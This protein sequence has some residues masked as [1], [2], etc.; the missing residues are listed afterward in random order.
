MSIKHLIFTVLLAGSLG[1]GCANAS[2]FK[3]ENGRIAASST[4][5]GQALAYSC[6]GAKIQGEPG[7]LWAA[8]KDVAKD[9]NFDMAEITRQI[10]FTRLPH[11]NGLCVVARGGPISGELETVLS[12][13]LWNTG[14]KEAGGV[15]GD[16]VGI[17][18][19]AV[20]K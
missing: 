17:G 2:Y 1:L 10:G 20:N 13:W 12:A 19:D 6:K 5:L 4:A 9:Q 18:A 8:L 11:G 3:G 16:A 14:I 15:L 7:E